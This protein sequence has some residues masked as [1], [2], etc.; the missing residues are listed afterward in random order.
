[1]FKGSPHPNVL[2]VSSFIITPSYAL[3]TMAI[4]PTMLNVKLGERSARVRR[5]IRG[6]L[7]GTDFLHRNRVSH[8]DIKPANV[9]ISV[10]DEPV[11]IDFGCAA[12]SRLFFFNP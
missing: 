11:L 7:E 12:R 1:M 6:L 10:E 4:H 8:N 5:Y 2:R 9:V 3:L